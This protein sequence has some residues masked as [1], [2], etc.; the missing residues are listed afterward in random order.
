[1][2]KG[3]RIRETSHVVFRF[4]EKMMR[5]VSFSALRVGRRTEKER[6]GRVRESRRQQSEGGS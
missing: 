1:M 3:D 2:S 4:D 5:Q 6:E